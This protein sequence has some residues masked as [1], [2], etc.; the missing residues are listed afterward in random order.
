V[1]VFVAG[2]TGLLGKRVV[3]QLVTGGHQV[4]GVSRSAVNRDRLA[5]LGAEPIECDIF[6]ADSVTRAAEGCGAVLHLA[7]KIPERQ[8]TSARHWAE[9]D[10]LRRDGTRAL[11]AAARAHG[12]RYVQQSVAWIYG[13]GGDEWLDEGAPMAPRDKLPANIVSAVDMEELVARSGVAAIVLRGGAFYA[14]DSSQTRLLITRLRQGMMRVPGDGRQFASFIHIDD[15][16][17]AVTKAT[18]CEDPITG[19]IFNIVDDEPVRF[20]D[21]IDFLSG[22]VG[23]QPPGGSPRWLLRLA[24]GKAVGDTLLASL[25]VSNARVKDRLGWEPRFPTYREGFDQV[26]AEL[27][28]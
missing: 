23:R 4:V 17:A 1:R 22:R 21:V 7:T 10:R 8:R 13:N 20:R 16:A 14:A 12:A 25:R 28:V 27:K 6:D 18:L 19:E 11:L 3:R 5:T 24:I 9:N 2:A 15:M 26:L